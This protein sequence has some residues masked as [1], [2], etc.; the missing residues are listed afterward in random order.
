LLYQRKIRVG[1][2][3]HEP[4]ICF[5]VDPVLYCCDTNGPTHAPT[6]LSLA[7]AAASVFAS[8][9]GPLWIVRCIVLLHRVVHSLSVRYCSSCVIVRFI[10][11]A[12]LCA[13]I[14][15]ILASNATDPVKPITNESIM[16]HHRVINDYHS[17]MPI[18]TY[19][20]IMNRS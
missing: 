16:S 15:S 6:I 19:Y 8:S 5:R 3:E 1:N 2:T 11:H 14:L 13:L 17:S 20:S 12:L 10:H 18:I 4:Y 9:L 7:S